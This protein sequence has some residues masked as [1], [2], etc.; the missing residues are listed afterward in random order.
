[1]QYLAHSRHRQKIYWVRARHWRLTPR[2]LTTQEPEIRRIV[3][4][5]QPGKIVWETISQ[6]YPT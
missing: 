1:M 2:I 4:Q 6:K 3:A 5:I